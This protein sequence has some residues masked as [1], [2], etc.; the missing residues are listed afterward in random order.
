MQSG[1]NPSSSSVSSSTSA[2]QPTAG[3]PLGPVSA[4]TCGWLPVATLTWLAVV[5]AAALLHLRPPQ[6][7]PAESGGFSTS[8]ALQHL[9]VI[10]REPHPLGS[11][12]NGRVREYLQQT[13]HE[14]GYDV[15]LQRGVVRSRWSGQDHE[16]VN[17][18]ARYGG[19]D[20]RQALLLAAHYDSV[21]RGPGAADDGAAVAALL[22]VAR[23]LRAEPRPRN[24]LVILLTDG[25]EAGL[26]G[27]QLF[28]S[29]PEQLQGAALVFNFEARGTSGP[30]V[31]FETSPA[32]G[33]LVADFGRLAPHPVTTSLAAEVYQHMPNDTD[34]SVFRRAGLRGLNFAFIGSAENYHTERDD[35]QHLDPAS[36]RHHGLQALA[37]ARHFLDV[38]FTQPQE[39]RSVIY[40][41]FLWSGVVRYPQSLALPLAVLAAALLL[42]AIGRGLA[43]GRLQAAGLRRGLL[44]SLLVVV[45]A[46]GLAHAA[47]FALRAAWPPVDFDLA[48][49]GFLLLSMAAAL[50][51]TQLAGRWVG[52]ANVAVAGLVWVSLAAL[53]SAAWVPAASYIVLWPM[54]SAVL[55]WVGLWRRQAGSRPAAL[56]AVAVNGLAAP[57]VIV[58]LPIAYVMLQALGSQLAF[59]VSPFAVLLV[60]S[61]VP[62]LHGLARPYGVWLWPVLAA[63]AA[64]C[65]LRAGWA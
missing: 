46:A 20:G 36:L 15:E 12:A 62:Q 52:G 63:G 49:A 30:S 23:V 17:V 43:D 65:L 35:V 18:I 31:M 16:P 13:L 24:D 19:S 48:A 55:A 47:A 9:Q 32:A 5:C 2:D 29:D 61:L 56:L 41:S 51:G 44:Y 38:D 53:A 14:L 28:V 39:P 54:A 34:F 1:P 3:G 64:A 45:A 11:A 26:L 33:E 59:A 40:F 27:A 37:L 6:S 42:G 57:G 8:R 4:R 60:W 50:L 10:A 21:S 22:E 58:L 7:D 25:E